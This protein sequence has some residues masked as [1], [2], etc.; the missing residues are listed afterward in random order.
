VYLLKGK[1]IPVKASWVQEVEASR[2]P[3]NRHMK[4]VRLSPYEP[5]AFT[6]QEIYLLEADSIPGP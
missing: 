2:F 6:L 5:A 4:V 3:D 1:A